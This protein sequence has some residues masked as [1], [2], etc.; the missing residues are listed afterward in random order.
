MKRGRKARKDLV[1]RK[2]QILRELNAKKRINEERVS[3]GVKVKTFIAIHQFNDSEFE[4]NPLFHK[5]C[6][7]LDVQRYQYPNG[8]QDVVKCWVRS[9]ICVIRIHS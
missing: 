6:Q 5:M 3:H 8:T 4:Q 1:E 9:H 7:I 2:F